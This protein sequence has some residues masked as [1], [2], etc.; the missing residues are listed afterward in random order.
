MPSASR[1]STGSNAR[2]EGRDE[3]A[4]QKDGMAAARKVFGDGVDIIRKTILLLVGY[5]PFLNF[6]LAW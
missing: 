6:F 1:S 5:I 4:F 3:G 2:S